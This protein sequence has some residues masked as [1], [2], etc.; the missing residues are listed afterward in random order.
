MNTQ[1]LLP[2]RETYPADIHQIYPDITQISWKPGAARPSTRLQP[3]G[4]HRRKPTGKL[5]FVFTNGRKRI[6]LYNFYNLGRLGFNKL[7]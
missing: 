2:G 4:D 7:Q 3:Q 1:I 6:W 5:C